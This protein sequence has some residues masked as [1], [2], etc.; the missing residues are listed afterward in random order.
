MVKMLAVLDAAGYDLIDF[1]E[2]LFV[3]SNAL[4]NR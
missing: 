1:V 2:F 4:T 3:K